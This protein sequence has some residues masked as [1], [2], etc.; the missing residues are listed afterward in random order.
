MAAA[1]PALAAGRASTT[2]RVSAKVVSW[3]DAVSLATLPGGAIPI[4]YQSADPAQVVS[5]QCGAGGKPSA[6][7]PA[8]LPSP[9]SGG[10]T[11]GLPSWQKTSVRW[12][13]GASLR[14]ARPGGAGA[15]AVLLV[16]F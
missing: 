6:A 14:L 13:E 2:I 15:P 5:M 1:L 11:S 3:C 12:P 8:S 16:E 9:S 10:A 4:A 7:S